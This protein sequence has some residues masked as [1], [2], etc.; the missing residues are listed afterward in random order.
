MKYPSYIPG[1]KRIG[2]IC[3]WV[4]R[5]KTAAAAAAGALTNAYTHVELRYKDVSQT[6]EHDMR[7]DRELK[8]SS[9]PNLIVEFLEQV[10]IGK[11]VT[12]FEHDTIAHP[13]PAPEDFQTAESSKQ[14]TPMAY[15]EDATFHRDVPKEDSTLLSGDVFTAFYRQSLNLSS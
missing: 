9:S 5:R 1:L 2:L 8:I 3:S 15:S 13:A 11:G 14:A 4:L 7:V 10:M 12:L 6:G